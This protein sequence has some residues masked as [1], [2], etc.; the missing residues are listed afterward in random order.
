MQL[1]KIKKAK[2]SC[3]GNASEIDKGLLDPETLIKNFHLIETY[4]MVSS[5]LFTALYIA[6]NSYS[7]HYAISVES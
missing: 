2:N 6:A 5:L 4:S 1:G 7:C 3:K